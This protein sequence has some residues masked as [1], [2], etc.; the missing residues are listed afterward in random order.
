V[1][2]TANSAVLKV[3]ICAE[4]SARNCAV[5]RASNCAVDKA[6]NAV[7]ESVDTKEEPRPA[8]AV[9]LSPTRLLVAS[10][11]RTVEV[12]ELIEPNCAVVRPAS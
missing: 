1:V 8:I 7:L 10:L 11:E 5:V 2:N 9:V 6:L 4:V 3:P 12:N